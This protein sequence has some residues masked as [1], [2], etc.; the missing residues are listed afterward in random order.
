[1]V[2]RP[3]KL[4]KTYVNITDYNLENNRLFFGDDSLFTSYGKQVT[5]RL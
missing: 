2:T 4:I 5:E 1:M 3:T